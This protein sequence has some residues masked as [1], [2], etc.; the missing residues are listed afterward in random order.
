V[1]AGAGGTTS[2]DLEERQR[3]PGASG[4]ARHDLL[5][6][7]LVAAWTAV[8]A[9]DPGG[10]RVPWHRDGELRVDDPEGRRITVLSTALAPPPGGPAGASDA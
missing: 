9:T 7:P 4:E 2:P 6:A 5:P 10:G 8:G 3:R 1:D